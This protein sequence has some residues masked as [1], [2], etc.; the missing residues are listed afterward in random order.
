MVN[1]K[2]Y[3]I[4]HYIFSKEKLKYVYEKTKEYNKKCKNS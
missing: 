2:T 1:K 4:D 3:W